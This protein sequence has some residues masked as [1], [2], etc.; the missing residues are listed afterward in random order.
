MARIVATVVAVYGVWS[1]LSWLGILAYYF[2]LGWRE[3]G[4]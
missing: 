4:R 2:Y 1:G 3:R